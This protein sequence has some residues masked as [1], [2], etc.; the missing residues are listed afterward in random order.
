[1]FGLLCTAPA[2]QQNGLRRVGIVLSILLMGLTTKGSA[3]HDLRLLPVFADCVGTSWL[4]YFWRLMPGWCSVR[5]G[6]HHHMPFFDVAFLWSL[7]ARE[8]TYAQERRRTEHR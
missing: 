1:M 3:I 7:A 8:R 5:C 6:I 2:A 4:S